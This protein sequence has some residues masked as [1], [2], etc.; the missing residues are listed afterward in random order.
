MT[1]QDIIGQI[2]QKK[3]VLSIG[4]DPVIERMPE[5]IRASKDPLFEFNKAIVDATHDL[6][7]AYKPNTA[8]Y[9][10]YG[11]KGWESL[12]KTAFYIK[13]NY[14]EMF[15]IADAKRGDI[16][17]TS[18]MYAKAF[19]ENMPF[20]AVTLTP[21]LGRDVAQPFLEYDGKWVIL[22]G[23]SSNPSAW[24]IQLI[25]E[26]ET[27]D[28]IF[29]KIFKYGSWWGDENKVMFVAGA[30]LAYKLQQIRHIVPKHFLLV[31]GIGAQG[32]NLEEVCQFG[33]NENY[34]LIINSSRSIIY[35]GEGEDFAR[36]AREKAAEYSN[37]MK[38]QIEKNNQR[39][40]RR[41]R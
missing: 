22:V 4:L 21:Y 26:I 35:A 15:L 2:K 8:F 39:K 14:P 12:E 19:F 13:E 5:H 38:E 29:E 10:A 25:Q 7:I 11:H 16:S 3:T 28:Y 23:L 24:D 27:R 40:S 32:G 17:H 33:M 41:R 9:E 34:G 31:P 6:A 1:L 37:A 30:T 18:A 20:D 36:K